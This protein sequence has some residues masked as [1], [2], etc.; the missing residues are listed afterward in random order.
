MSALQKTWFDRTA[1]RPFT[2]VSAAPASSTLAPLL[3]VG[4]VG[5]RGQKAHHASCGGQRLRLCPPATSI[6]SLALIAPLGLR[7]IGPAPVA[8]FG[9]ILAVLIDVAPV[10]DQLVAIALLCVGGPRSQSRHAFDNVHC[11]MK[12]I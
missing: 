9:H 10:L 2:P 8:N 4:E 1:C 7:P 6:Q 3:A 12:A 5:R 11:Q